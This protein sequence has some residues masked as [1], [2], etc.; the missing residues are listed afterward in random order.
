MHRAKA[1][2]A[3][4]ATG[5]QYFTFTPKWEN[6][7]LCARCMEC[8]ILT[9]T[10]GRY[11]DRIGH[12]EAFRLPGNKPFGRGSHSSEASFGHFHQKPYPAISGGSPPIE[13]DR[14]K[15]LPCVHQLIPQ[16]CADIPQDI[17]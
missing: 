17:I 15:S 4:Y 7:A 14:R 12:K 9:P 8:Y 2:K 10:G 11:E 16:V 3:L 5:A 1:G 6:Y 13:N